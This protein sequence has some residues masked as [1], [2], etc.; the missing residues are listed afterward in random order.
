MVKGA[1]ER[2]GRRKEGRHQN[3][4]FYADDG[5]V[6]S[7]EPRWLQGIFGTLSGIFDRVGLKTNVRK[8]FGMVCCLFQAA[9]TKSEAAYGG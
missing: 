4:L 7:S 1:D 6:T 2:S 9:G 3:S 8:T 5:M